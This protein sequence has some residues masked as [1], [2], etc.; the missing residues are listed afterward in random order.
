MTIPMAVF[1]GVS[2]TFKRLGADG[3]LAAAQRE[4]HGVRRLIAPVL[5]AAAGVALLALVANTQV[6]PRANA[7]LAAVLSNGAPRQS[8]R[9]MTVG[10]LRAAARNARVTS[11]AQ[12]ASFEVEI[13]KKYALAA[14]CVVL[15]LAAAAIALRFPRGGKALVAIA[16]VVVFGTYY[17]ATI[18][19]EGLAD[20]GVVSPLVGM[21]MANALLFAAAWLVVWS[22][23]WPRAA[24]GADS[25][26]SRA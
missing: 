18:T 2:W 3:M 12:A 4:R 24:Q 16:S 21:W 17:L 22:G 5:G 10:Q 6:L 25:L 1:F 20:R 9:T 7:R 15:A 8:D 19:G 14:A 23:Q 26:A 11:P 13:Q